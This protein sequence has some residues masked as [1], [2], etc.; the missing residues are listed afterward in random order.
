MSSFY[1]G[2]DIGGTNVVCGLVD[3][4]GRVLHTVKQPTGAQRGSGAVLRGVADLIE[5]LAQEAGHALH[6][7]AAV[8]VGTPGLVDPQR[9]IT[10]HASNLGWK[11]V[12]VAAIL[13]EH[14]RLPVYID[15][16]VR[17]YVYGEAT[18][19]AGR[20]YGTVMGITLGTGM[21]MSVIQNGTIYY[22]AHYMAG[23][24]GHLA[25]DGIPYRCACGLSGCLETVV[26]A[27]GIV[28]QVRDALAKG[29]A[30]SL[31]RIPSDQ[32]TAAAV[33]EAY[34]AGDPLAVRVF[35]DTGR[36]LGIGLS[37]AITLFDPDVL[38]IGGGMSAAGERL[39]RP[40]KEQLQKTLL[41][42]Y[43][44]RLV[45][46][47]ARHPDHAGVIGSAMSAKSRHAAQQ[48]VTEE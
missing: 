44:E 3:A 27:T 23:E 14:L 36:W 22:G 32:L 7:T 39:F 37:Y 31:G 41:G 20:G 19:G 6:S 30:S 8:G 15:N 13:A 26:S 4:Q 17:M 11:D 16:D 42:S 24:L 48:P 9:G 47:P 28:R 10:L 43:L 45:I 29:E 5:R 25:M 34:D 2:V 46:A 21:A 33:S 18:A 1:I 40:M 35:N 12:P 38:I